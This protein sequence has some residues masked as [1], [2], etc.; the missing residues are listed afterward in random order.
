MLTIEYADH[1]EPISDVNSEPWALDVIEQYTIGYGKD[2]DVVVSNELLIEVFRVLIYEGK[3]DSKQIRFLYKGRYIYPYK[4]GGV[5][6]WPK[7]FCDYTINML[8]R[9]I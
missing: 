6:N 2:R 4:D 1:G 9:L 3:I 5:M 7:G 8:E